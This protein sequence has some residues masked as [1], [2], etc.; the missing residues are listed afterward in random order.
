MSL[1]APTRVST[2]IQIYCIVVIDWLWWIL[3]SLGLSMFSGLGWV[4][5][6][7]FLLSFVFLRYCYRLPFVVHRTYT[8]PNETTEDRTQNDSFLFVVITEVEIRFKMLLHLDKVK[9]IGHTISYDMSVDKTKNWPQEP[10]F[11]T[12][13]KSS[14]SQDQES[15]T[16]LIFS[17][18]FFNSF[19]HWHR[20]QIPKEKYQLY[21]NV[22]KTEAEAT[23]RYSYSHG[24]ESVFP[25][26]RGRWQRHNW[27]SHGKSIHILYG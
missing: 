21:K 13:S 16:T 12:N 8:V 17:L 22:I 6:G 7:S 3:V 9:L 5:V 20:P 1:Y 2:R 15:C 14:K 23:R 27:S 4:L 25:K 24:G 26:A 18:T 11:K 10:R 19:L